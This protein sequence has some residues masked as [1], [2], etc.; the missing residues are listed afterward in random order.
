MTEN[1]ATS[2]QLPSAV[3]AVLASIDAGVAAEIRSMAA[4]GVVRLP[5]PQLQVILSRITMRRVRI[6]QYMPV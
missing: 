3:A 2:A 1:G 5:W 6:D 4:T